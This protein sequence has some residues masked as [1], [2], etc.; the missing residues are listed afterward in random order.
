M[1]LKVYTVHYCSKVW[2]KLVLYYRTFIKSDSILNKCS[3]Y[4]KE[5]VL[6]YILGY[7]FFF[8]IPSKENVYLSLDENI[9]RNFLQHL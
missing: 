1:N 8:S 5:K 3:F 7:T 2:R 6:G 9:K 4:S